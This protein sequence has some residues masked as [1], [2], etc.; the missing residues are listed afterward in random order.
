MHWNPL[1]PPGFVATEFNSVGGPA[2]SVTQIYEIDNVQLIMDIATS[3]ALV[4]DPTSGKARIRNVSNADVT[5]DYYRIESTNGSLLTANFN[6]TTGWNSL[7]DQGLD[8]IG[9]GVGESWDEVVDANSANRLVEQFLLGATTLGAGQ[10]VSLGAPVN[11]AILNNQSNTLALRFGGAAYDSEGIGQVIFQDLST[12]AG[13]YNGNGVVDTA[14][15]VMWR[16][17]PN[18][19]GG[20]PGGYNTWR[21]NFGASLG[22]GSALGDGFERSPGTS[23]WPLL[24]FGNL[25]GGRC[26][27]PKEKGAAVG[28]RMIPPMRRLFVPC[29]SKTSQH[30]LQGEEMLARI[31][32]ILLRRQ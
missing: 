6:G 13:D 22:A 11:P 30:A 28:A 1:A 25:S 27:T 21:A 29:P 32:R 20:D 16:E 4:V 19:F 2:A 14:D 3:L 26:A 18:A 15:Y 7:D 8:S 10:S 5:F 12:L 31:Y 23:R 9:A 24:R 17:N